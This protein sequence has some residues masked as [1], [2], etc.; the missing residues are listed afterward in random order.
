MLFLGIKSDVDVSNSPAGRR[1]Q[2][3]KLSASA[4]AAKI[5]AAIGVHFGQRGTETGRTGLVSFQRLRYLN[6]CGGARLPIPF[7]QRLKRC[8]RKPCLTSHSP[9]SCR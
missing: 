9:R 2:M 7:L 4:V 3:A 5:K 6:F 8:R 1:N